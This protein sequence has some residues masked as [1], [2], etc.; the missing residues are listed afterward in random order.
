VNGWRSDG[1]F[2]VGLGCLVAGFGWVFATQPVGSDRMVALQVGQGDCTVLQV[3]GRT[4]MIDAGP[5]GANFDSGRRVVWPMLRR[6]GVRKIDLLILTH[7]DLDHVGGL[8]SLAELIPIDQVVMSEA[9]RYHPM[10]TSFPSLDLR[11]I[12]S[13]ES[14]QIGTAEL[15][16]RSYLF[17]PDDNE[18]S[19]I[20]RVK[21]R[22]STAVFTGD[23]GFREEQAI[24]R[25]WSG[26]DWF[27]AGHHGSD[28]STSTGLLQAW[29]PNYLLVS[30]G[31]RNRFGHPSPRVVAEGEAVGAR[32]MRTDLMGHLEFIPTQNG[33]QFTR[34]LRNP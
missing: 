25:E 30:C 8:S 21:W 3:E 34:I 10:V 15:D 6:L 29:K 19:L 31:R 14:V 24:L 1:A 7:P 23:A 16:F 18:R 12:R 5:A 22:G 26:A 33:W 4:V 27:K 28:E 13:G 32:V 11:F 2:L 20:T 17:G 9:F